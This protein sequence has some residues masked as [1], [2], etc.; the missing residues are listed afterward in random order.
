MLREFLPKPF[1][2]FDEL[3]SSSNSI[4]HKLSWKDKI[5]TMENQNLDNI[6]SNLIKANT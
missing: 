4:F 1:G 2:E 3:I 6:Y 5:C